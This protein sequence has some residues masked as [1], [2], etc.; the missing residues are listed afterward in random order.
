MDLSQSRSSYLTTGRCG[1]GCDVSPTPSEPS[2]PPVCAEPEPVNC[3]CACAAG[4]SAALQLL[5][6]AQLAELTD[7]SQFA[8]FTDGFILGTSLRCPTCDETTYDNLTGP[9]AGE[10][11]RI[12]PCT[13]ENLAVAGKLYYPVP[14]CSCEC[15]CAGGVAFMPRELPLC[16]IRAVAFGVAEGACCAETEQNYLQLKTLLWQALHCGSCISNSPLATKPTPCDAQT[17][18]I[19]GRRTLSLTAGPLLVA[20]AAVL[21]TVGDVIV[22]ANDKDR[23]FYF[24]CCGAVD[25]TD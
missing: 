10:F 7:F 20:G 19:E 17:G 9:L 13:C 11:V 14:V 23:R 18:C 12:T 15:C 6:N 4:M 25:F 5:C 1:C 21:G 2:C 3:G 24:V 16:A 22:L 8:F